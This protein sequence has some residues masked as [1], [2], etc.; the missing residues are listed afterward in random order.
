MRYDVAVIGAGIMGAA[1]AATLAH[2]GRKVVLLEQFGVGHERGSSHGRSRIFRYSY[3]DASFVAMAMEALPLWREYEWQAD[4]PLVTNTGGFD[5]GEGI[6]KNLAALEECGARVEYLSGREV[7]S[8]WP[9]VGIAPDEDAVFQPDAGMI[10]ADRALNAFIQVARDGG[11]QVKERS[12]VEALEQHGDRVRLVSGRARVEAAACVVT[13]GAWAQPLLATA[14]IELDVKP[15]RETVVYYRNARALQPTFVDWGSPAVYAL[16]SP[17]GELK[18]GEH[19]AGPEIDPAETGSASVESADRVT[20]W[21]TERFPEADPKAI[22]TETCLY[23]NTDDQSFVLESKE[24]IVVGSA[25]SGHGFKFA[26]LIGRRL[27]DLA[28]EINEHKR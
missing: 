25:C 5:V 21:V 19:I 18:A 13:A 1:T 14:G 22:R 23:T 7:S 27:A 12:P 11:A 8:R 20:K 16:P 10:Y 3:P 4:E 24:R 28:D 9:F 17:G 15:T 26:P 2:R 6:E